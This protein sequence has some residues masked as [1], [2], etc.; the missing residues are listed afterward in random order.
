MAE[1]R[2]FGSGKS[3]LEQFSKVERLDMDETA[4]NGVDQDSLADF[5]GETEQR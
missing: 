1:G 3:L 4:T 5:T 2:I